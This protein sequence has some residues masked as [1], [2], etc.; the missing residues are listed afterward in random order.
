MTMIKENAFFIKRTFHHQRLTIDKY[1]F[2]S[3]LM[4]VFLRLHLYH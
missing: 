3:D 2:I 4:T 1:I